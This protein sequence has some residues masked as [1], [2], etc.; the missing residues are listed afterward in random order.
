VR[1]NLLSSTITTHGP[2]RPFAPHGTFSSV[3]VSETARLVR[4]P[5]ASV[6]L[7]VLRLEA[8]S[9]PL[10]VRSRLRE[11]VLSDETMIRLLRP[12]YGK[13]RSLSRLH[14]EGW[15]SKVCKFVVSLAE[16][17][18]LRG[19]KACV[20][21]RVMQAAPRIGKRLTRCSRSFSPM[22]AWQL[23]T[24]TTRR[25]SRTIIEVEAKSPDDSTGA[26]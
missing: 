23:M 15:K 4:V 2:Q 17:L 11:G 18:A 20:G 3:P 24:A 6:H 9:G 25:V 14:S 22:H 5:S 10:D 7:Q 12:L 19:I 16:R 21:V 26:E 1:W 8:G 13:S